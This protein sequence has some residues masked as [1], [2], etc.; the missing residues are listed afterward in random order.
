MLERG[1]VESVGRASVGGGWGRRSV[2][3]TP[4]GE[5]TTGRGE[6]RRVS[7]ESASERLRARGG[8]ST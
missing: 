4:T 1:A 2:S 8:D 5:G 3:R 7:E 6:G